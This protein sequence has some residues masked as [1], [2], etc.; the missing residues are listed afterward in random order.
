MMNMSLILRFLLNLKN[1][2]LPES[3]FTTTIATAV[4][5]VLGHLLFLSL[6]AVAVGVHH[7]TR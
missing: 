3:S 6:G 7:A 1:V 4:A 2:V 5:V